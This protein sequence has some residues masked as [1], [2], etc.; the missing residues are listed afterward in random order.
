MTKELLTIEHINAQS[1][2]SNYEEVKLLIQ[3]RD[4]DV[5]CVSETWLHSHTSDDLIAIPDYILFRNDG[6]RGG[7]VCIYVRNTLKTHVINLHE[8][9][10]LTPP[11]IE[12]LF[13]TVQHCMLPATIIGC[14]YRHPKAPAVSFE[15]ICNT[16]QSLCISKKKCLF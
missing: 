1:L 16:L 5:L 15:Y 3:E 9:D 13:L 2:Q 6:G 8:P 10:E 4:V 11:D 12:G 7:G 14:I